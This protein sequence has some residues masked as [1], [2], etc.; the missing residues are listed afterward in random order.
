MA[1]ILNVD[2][3]RATGSTTD[4]LT[5]NSSGQVA[6]PALPFAMVTNTS[7]ATVTPQTTV[8]FNNVISSRGISWDTSAYTF[9]VPVTG[10][11]SFSGALRVQATRDFLWW[12]VADNSG[13]HLQTQKLVLAHGSS[14][15]FT[16][17]SG[18]IL[19]SLTAATNYKI[20]FNDSGGGSS[21]AITVNQTWMDVHLVG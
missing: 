3:I 9:T 5:V 18:S 4:G 10:I 1:S 14:G 21:V 17:A 16:T 12:G 15:N 2:K 11:Y 19:A 7:G 20:I 6:Q 8:P 13:N